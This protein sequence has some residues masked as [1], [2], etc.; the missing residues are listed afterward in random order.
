VNIST[1]Q[2]GLCLERSEV[3]DHQKLMG[4]GVRFIIPVDAQVRSR[5]N[6]CSKG[7]NKMVLKRNVYVKLS[8]WLGRG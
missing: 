4:V 6:G 3:E 5:G 8:N 2:S 1:P 7:A